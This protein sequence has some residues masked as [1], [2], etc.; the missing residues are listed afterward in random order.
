MRTAV[1]GLQYGDEGKARVTGYYQT[2]YDI[3]WSIRYNGG[4]NAGHT[5]YDESGIEF[6]LHCV[7][8]GAVFKGRKCAIDVGC[9]LNLNCLKEE[10]KSLKTPINLHISEGVHLITKR[11]LD[12]DSGGSGIGSTKRGI[13]YA[14][15]DKALRR[16]KRI[17]AE[18]LKNY[19]IDAQIYRG[20]PPVGRNESAL[21]EGAQAIMLDI[22]YGDYPYVSS[23]SVMPS[24]AHRIDKIVGVMKA[25]TTRVGNGP[26]NY[27]TIPELTTAGNE[28]GTTTGRPRKCYWNDMDQIRYAL[29]VVQPDEVV[30]T[31]MDILK[32]IPNISVYENG[33]CISVGNLDA[34]KSY[35]LEHFPEITW[36]SESP[37]GDLIGTR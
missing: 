36:F 22:D 21:Y 3:L 29:S 30:V 26:P 19:E 27:P 14:Y 2:K 17:T 5:V 4:N 37:H 16:G 8:V 34:Y 32:D 35:L 31:K 18:D 12:L 9:V 28:Y 23:S 13:S 11:H 6:K 15:A 20:L 25:Y 1:V 33:R 24:T 7:P 10:L